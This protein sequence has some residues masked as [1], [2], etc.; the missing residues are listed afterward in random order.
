MHF[1]IVCLIKLVSAVRLDWVLPMMLLNSHVTWSCI[2]HAYVL[3]F[4]PILSLCCVSFCFLLFFLSLLD[5]LRYGT[6]I[7]QIY[8]GSESFLRFQAILF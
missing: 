8:S 5:R 7:A 2:F 1:R 3:S 4:F 6:Q